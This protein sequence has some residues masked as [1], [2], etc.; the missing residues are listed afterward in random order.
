MRLSDFKPELINKAIEIYLHNAYE[1]DDLR[2]AH[3]L[4]FGS[5]TSLKEILG[6]F[7]KDAG[8][9]LDSYTLRLGCQHYPHM[10]L[11][12]WEAYY[13]GEY[14]FAVDRHDGFNFAQEMPDFESWIGIKSK[15]FKIKKQIEEEWYKAGV[16]TLRSIREEKLSQSDIMREFSGSYVLVV[17]NDEDAGGILDLIL[18]SA[19]YGSIWV[20][21]KRKALELLK[22]KEKAEKIGVAIVDILLSD[23][24]G[25]DVVKA[26][27]S[28]AA[29]QDIPVILSSA[30]NSND[31]Y[32]AEADGYL[33]KPFSAE[34][35]VET[36]AEAIRRGYGGRGKVKEK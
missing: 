19:G 17:E 26:L 6:K 15:N 11:S 35:L 7:E 20:G 10:K 13:S 8:L 29:T 22:D 14:V 21:S 23:G 33:R 9:K 24:T 30:M 34:K 4:K 2:Q 28:N 27:R 12:L 1:N 16:P 3:A 5:S 31:V 32:M 25:A 18:S 36:V